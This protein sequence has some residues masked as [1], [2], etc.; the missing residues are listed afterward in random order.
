MKKGTILSITF[1][2]I[3][4][5]P[6]CTPRSEYNRALVRELGSGKRSDSLFL[7]LYLGMPE[8]DFYVHCWK[9][10][11]KGLVRQ[12]ESNTTVLYEVKNAL[13]HPA[14]CDFYPHFNQGK[15]FEMPVRYHY[16]GWVPWNKELSSEK[17]QDDVLN[18]YRKTYG[19]DFIKIRHPKRG[20]AWVKLDDNRRITIFMEDELHVW[21][22]FTDMSVK[23]NWSG[24]NADTTQN[25]NF[26][27]K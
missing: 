5:I 20:D 3:L 7:G 16:K 26:T 6:A 11:K 19:R 14:L 24:I 13:K 1:F 21:A 23:T 4:S 8:K 25:M 17:L 22:V 12:G 2:V 27:K 10:N 9:L 18:W 15:I